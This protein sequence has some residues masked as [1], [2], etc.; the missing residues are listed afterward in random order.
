MHSKCP[1]KL[2]DVLKRDVP[3]A[4][5]DAADIGAVETG[6]KGETL[7]GQ[8]LLLPQFSDAVAE[9]NKHSIHALIIGQDDSMSTDFKYRQQSKGR[10]RGEWSSGPVV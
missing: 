3:L 7:L 1:R 9:P 5:L 4:A 2:L 10:R 6:L 8:T